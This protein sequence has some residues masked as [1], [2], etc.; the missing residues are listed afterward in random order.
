MPQA[1]RKIGLIALISFSL[2]IIGVPGLL[3][4]EGSPVPGNPKPPWRLADEGSPVPGNP[5]PP[6]RLVDEGSPVPG[7]PKPPWRLV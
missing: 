3:A 5:K 6:W 1:L 7:N 4:D 2:T